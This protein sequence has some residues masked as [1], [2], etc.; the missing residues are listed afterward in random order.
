ML[1]ISLDGSDPSCL[2]NNH[3][4]SRNIACLQHHEHRFPLL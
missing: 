4:G 2:M 1:L 3:K